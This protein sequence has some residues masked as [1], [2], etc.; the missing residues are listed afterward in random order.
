MYF[1]FGEFCKIMCKIYKK[2]NEKAKGEKKK[3]I[4]KC[5][6][7]GERRRS[8]KVRVWSPIILLFATV[9]GRSLAANYLL[10]TRVAFLYSATKCSL[11]CPF[12]NVECLNKNCDWQTTTMHIGRKSRASVIDTE[13]G[14]P[15]KL[16]V[17]NYIKSNAL[18][19]VWNWHNYGAMFQAKTR[20]FTLGWSGWSGV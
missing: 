19:S 6:K 17:G 5:F 20:R 7:G 18:K 15:H 3:S 2:G 11:L 13:A 8:Q 1:P 4:K 14:C 10:T 9:L 16:F 12:H